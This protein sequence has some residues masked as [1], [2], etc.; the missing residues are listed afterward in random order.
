MNAM[1]LCRHISTMA[2]LFCAATLFMSA[3]TS[4]AHS[5]STSILVA[6]AASLIPAAAVAV[7]GGGVLV[8]N[9]GAWANFVGGVMGLGGAV[10]LVLDPPQGT[11]YDGSFSIHYPGDLFQ[12][13]RTGWLGNWGADP[14]L[15]APPANP[16]EWAPEFLV[17]LQNPHPGL[18]TS[19][20][21]DPLAG[22]LSG[23]FDWGVNGHAVEGVDHFTFFAAEVVAKQ[24]LAFRFLGNAAGPLPGANLYVSTPG[25]SCSPPGL[26]L[27]G[28]C[29]EE[30][31]QYF[32]VSPIP[33]PSTLLL[34]GSALTGLGG[35][36]FRRH[37]QTRNLSERSTL[38]EKRSQNAM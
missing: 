23:T 8:A 30:T 21:N 16:S 32:E 12:V 4:P 20:T 19:I 31:T 18:S 24:D 25:F 10:V 26:D 33:E 38:G 36:V 6:P 1:L 14:S 9:T 27:I 2:R 13:S 29:G 28:K 34:L 7:S 5:A 17:A 22:L 11:Y 15:P 37:R 3:V 35:A